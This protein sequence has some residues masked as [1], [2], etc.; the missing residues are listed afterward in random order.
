MKE[1]LKIDANLLYLENLLFSLESYTF[2][3]DVEKKLDNLR[4]FVYKKMYS[5]FNEDGRDIERYELF[6]R[7]YLK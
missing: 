2:D 6:A 3:T 1:E 7:Y 4:K 5:K